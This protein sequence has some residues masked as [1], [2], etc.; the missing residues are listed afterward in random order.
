MKSP[1]MRLAQAIQVQREHRAHGRCLDRGRAVREV[2]TGGLSMRTTEKTTRTG[3]EKTPTRKT[4]TGRPGTALGGGHADVPLMDSSDMALE[5]SEQ[6]KTSRLHF[7]VN[8]DSIDPEV[9]EQVGGMDPCID[10]PTSITDFLTLPTVTRQRHTKFK[11]P[12]FDFVQPK[13]LTSD[14]FPQLQRN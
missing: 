10:T 13:I 3:Q 5:F 14:E 12:I 2:M 4:K 9:T 8:A 1:C 6:P 11:D 7:F